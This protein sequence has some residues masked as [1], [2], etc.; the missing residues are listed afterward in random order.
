VYTKV[1]FSWNIVRGLGAHQN[2]KNLPVG[3]ERDIFRTMQTEN[4]STDD[5]HTA[6]LFWAWRGLPATDFLV[7]KNP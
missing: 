1:S 4:Y 7:A 6:Q 5:H 3:Q 2:L